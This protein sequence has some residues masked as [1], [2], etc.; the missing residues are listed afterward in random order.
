VGFLGEGINDA[1]AL[2]VANLGMVVA[3]AS[4]IARESADIVLLEKDMRVIISGIREGRLVLGNTTKYMKSTLVSNFGNFYALALSSFVVDYLPMLPL[5]ILLLNLL[6]D[7]PMVSIATDNCDIKELDKPQ[8]YDIKDLALLSVF[9]GLV[10]TTF[11]FMFFGI[12][13]R[14]GQG[15]LYT[16]WFIGSVLTELVFVFSIRTKLWF[17]QAARP[18]FGLVF[19]SIAAASFAIFIPFTKIGQEV[20]KFVV[21]DWNHLFLIFSL[22]LL[23]FAV[24]EVVKKLYYHY[25]RG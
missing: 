18:S 19:F 15:F 5:Q 9:L 11:D 1:P 25:T 13:S 23:Y 22:V 10:S 17:F 3:E 4:D 14:L 12:F 24:T 2:K 20:F 21:L 8:R 6:S 7:F 16:G